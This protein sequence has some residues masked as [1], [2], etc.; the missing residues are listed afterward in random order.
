MINLIQPTYITIYHRVKSLKQKK[1]NRKRDIIYLSL[2]QPERLK[3]NGKH[4]LNFLK[5]LFNI[6]H[7]YNKFST[8]IQ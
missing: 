8:T 1:K 2:L 7:S 3:I 6:N 4:F 5:T